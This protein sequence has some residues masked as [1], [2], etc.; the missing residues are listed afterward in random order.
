MP[1][2]RSRVT[3]QYSVFSLGHDHVYFYCA[4][5]VMLGTSKHYL[6]PPCQYQEIKSLALLL[7]REHAKA[8]RAQVYAV[9]LPVYW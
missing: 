9:H 5:A 1:V 8:F 2:A 4:T 7:F 3:V 6:T